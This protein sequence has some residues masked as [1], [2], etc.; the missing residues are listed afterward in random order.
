MSI[1]FFI[2]ALYLRYSIYSKNVLPEYIYMLELSPIIKYPK[3][4]NNYKRYQQEKE[5]LIEESEEKIK[6][7]ELKKEMKAKLSEKDYRRWRAKEYYHR[8]KE[9][10]NKKYK[11]NKLKEL[12]EKLDEFEELAEDYPPYKTERDKELEL[13]NKYKGDLTNAQWRFVQ[14]WWCTPVWYVKHRLSAFTQPI[15]VIP[16]PWIEKCIIQRL[17]IQQKIY[18]FVKPYISEIDVRDYWLKEKQDMFNKLQY[19]FRPGTKIFELHKTK[20]ISQNVLAMIVDAVL[21]DKWIETIPYMW[22]CILCWDRVYTAMWQVFMVSPYN[23]NYK[24]I[25]EENIERIH[26]DTNN[27]LKKKTR[28]CALASASSCYLVKVPKD[29]IYNEKWEKEIMRWDYY[30]VPYKVKSKYKLHTS[31]YDLFYK[32]W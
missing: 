11:D 22:K 17:N 4:N 7:K 13:L 29:I 32:K 10:I 12:K 9:R 20:G 15:K 31:D 26:E 30:I 2:V 21:R 28:N 27:Y 5:R 18:N 16:N 1:L 23:S 24:Y 3:K 6:E 8:N 14:Y 25:N 19:A